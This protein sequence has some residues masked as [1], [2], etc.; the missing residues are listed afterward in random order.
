M[1]LQ[2]TQQERQKRGGRVG[3]MA[4]KIFESV[5]PFVKIACT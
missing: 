2:C 3:I 4:G 1:A 5:N